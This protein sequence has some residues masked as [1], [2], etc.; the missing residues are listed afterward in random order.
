VRDGEADESDGTD[1]RG[2]GAGKDDPG[3]RRHDA[4][5]DDILPLPARHI[6]A[7]REAIEHAAERQRHEDAEDE[8]GRNAKED[9]EGPAGERPHLPEA[10]LVERGG[11]GEEDGGGERGEDGCDGGAGEGELDGRGAVAAHCGDDVD[12]H[13]GEARAGEGEPDV[14][15]HRR[16]A[17]HGDADDDEGGGSG[18]DTHDSRIGEGIAG[19]ALH[20][21]TSEAEGKADEQTEERSRQAKLNDDSVGGDV[22][23]ESGQGRPHMGER[24]GPRAD[25]E[26]QQGHDHNHPAQEDE[27]EGQGTRTSRDRQCQSPTAGSAALMAAVKSRSSRA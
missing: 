9:V 3:E 26:A 23:I 7:Q 1:R 20:N 13:S 12:H 25:G 4:R 16:D 6:V 27:A 24:D 14:A 2:G 11:A 15:A 21:G 19:G 17:E 18:V 10:E 5:D 8:E 22:W